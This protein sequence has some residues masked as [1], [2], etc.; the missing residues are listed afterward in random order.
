VLL[1]ES[2]ESRG[3]DLALTLWFVLQVE[4]AAKLVAELLNPM[5]DDHNEHKQRQLRELAL[6]NG[7]L[8]DEEYCNICG[9]KGHRQF[10]CPSRQSE[11]AASPVVR[12]SVLVLVSGQFLTYGG[13]PRQPPCIPARL[14]IEVGR[15]W[16]TR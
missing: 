4:A 10:E 8:R 3:S 14:V 15:S 2:A 13:S 9:E 6:I 5:D 16:L 11:W 12:I 7:T 1:L